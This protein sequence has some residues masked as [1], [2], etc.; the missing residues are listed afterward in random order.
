MGA[1]NEI[2]GG[3][4][5]HVTAQE[6]GKRADAF[7]VVESNDAGVLLSRMRHGVVP[8]AMLNLTWFAQHALGLQERPI[9]TDQASHRVRHDPAG[10]VV[11]N[12][13]VGLQA[14]ERGA[15]LIVM[16]QALYRQ[17]QLTF[18]GELDD[19]WQQARPACP[20]E[21]ER[22]L[23]QM[24]NL[25]QAPVSVYALRSEPIHLPANPTISCGVT[26]FRPGETDQELLLRADQALYRAKREGRDRVVC[27][28][29]GEAAEPVARTAASA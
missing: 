14:L 15:P 22:F 21:T 8:R 23:A 20:V 12:S 5:G 17:P 9:E 28:D 11:I 4:G 1:N 10:V 18:T 19:F 2:V 16:G 3:A 26:T 13:T 27:L 7:C 24:K 6:I 25:T 29:Q